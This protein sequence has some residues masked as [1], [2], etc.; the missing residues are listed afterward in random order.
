MTK[1]VSNTLTRWHKIAERIRNAGNE[2]QQ[3]IMTAVSP[4]HQD[5]DT[6][7]VRKK[8]FQAAS[9]KALTEQKDLFLELQRALFAIRKALADANIKAGVS[10]LLNDIELHK[11][12]FNFYNNLIEKIGGDLSISEFESLA[13]R[14]TNQ[15][16]YGVSVTFVTPAAKAE[17]EATRDALRIKLNQLA[18]ELADANA[19]KITLPVSAAVAQAVGL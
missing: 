19:T 10:A 9:D 6:L 17:I 5:A 2:L 18:D 3:N 15:S 8:T 7:V 14:R 1:T 13:S 11:Q 16:M 12:E 4:G